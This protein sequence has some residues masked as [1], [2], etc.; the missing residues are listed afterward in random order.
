MR[1]VPN[2]HRADQRPVSN[3][4][5]GIT[6]RGIIELCLTI[7]AII[8]LCALA[9]SSIFLSHLSAMCMIAFFVLSSIVLIGATSGTLCV[10][11]TYISCKNKKNEQEI[12]AKEEILNAPMVD[13]EV[14]ED[15]ISIASRIDDDIK[16]V[17][18]AAVI[19]AGVNI[20][21]VVALAIACLVAGIVT[22]A[23]CGLIG[24]AWGIFGIMSIIGFSFLEKGICDDRI[25]EN[26]ASIDASMEKGLP[27]QDLD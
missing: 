13:P 7:S 9:L 26:W 17:E 2:A 14:I 19:A 11:L 6:N 25:K 5:K 10:L 23:T 16:K 22:G 8:C 27:L 20:G 18:T 15:D 1:V 24:L 12:F 3:P 21:V 4:L